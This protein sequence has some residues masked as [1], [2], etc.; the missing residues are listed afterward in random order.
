LS[1]EEK[2]TRDQ[3]KARDDLESMYPQGSDWRQ[4]EVWKRIECGWQDK[5][6]I[7]EAIDAGMNWLQ[8]NE[9]AEASEFKTQKKEIE[10]IVQ[11]ILAKVQ[12]QKH[13]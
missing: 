10:D 12:T 8:E 9:E 4:A 6:K 7:E 13:A 1:D 2:R 5:A 11:G 3:L